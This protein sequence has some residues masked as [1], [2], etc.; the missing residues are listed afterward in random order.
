MTEK[1][2]KILDML[3]DRKQR[4]I[5]FFFIERSYPVKPIKDA[6]ICYSEI[7]C[8]GMLT[9]ITNITDT[10]K[11]FSAAKQKL[12]ARSYRKLS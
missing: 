3:R 4:I 12:A 2:P 10:A 11:L 7:T 1:F 9:V 6:N 8:M 5:N